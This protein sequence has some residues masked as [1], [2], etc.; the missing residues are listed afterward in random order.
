MSERK[1]NIIGWGLFVAALLLTVTGSLTAEP[2][3]V[4]RKSIDI[5]M[6]CIGIG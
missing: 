3:S 6:E 4:F 5:C 1:R 2:E